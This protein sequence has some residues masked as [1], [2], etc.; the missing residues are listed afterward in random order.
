M[1][2]SEKINKKNSPAAYANTCCRNVA[3]LYWRLFA[4]NSNRRNYNPPARDCV[5][6]IAMN[7]LV[8]KRKCPLPTSQ[9]K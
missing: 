7:V 2:Y 5:C 3:Y 1:L 4:F 8:A 6:S 9:S